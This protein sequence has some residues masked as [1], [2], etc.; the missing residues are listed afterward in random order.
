MVLQN[1]FSDGISMLFGIIEEKHFVN[2]EQI[3]QDLWNKYLTV[4][5]FYTAP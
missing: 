4:D 3:S 2:D 5:L 1:A